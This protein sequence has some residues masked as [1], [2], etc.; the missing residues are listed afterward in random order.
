MADCETDVLEFM[1]DSSLSEAEIK[2]L[3]NDAKIQ[4]DAVR[5]K[6][7]AST[8]MKEWAAK[9]VK[10]EQLKA[11]IKKRSAGMNTLRKAQMLEEIQ[12]QYPAGKEQAIGVMSMIDG[13]SLLM[14]LCSNVQDF[15]GRKP[16]C[17]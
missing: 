4:F 9:Q 12:T 2:G 3:V 15:T 11:L 5:N 1:K 7:N 8:L 10:N 17:F 14:L 16:P 6:P 13:D